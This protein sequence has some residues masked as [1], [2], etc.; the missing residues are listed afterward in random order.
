MSKDYVDLQQQLFD[1]QATHMQELDAYTDQV[2]TAKEALTLHQ[3]DAQRTLDALKADHK[4]LLQQTNEKHKHELAKQLADHESQ[5]QHLSGKEQGELL[6][7][8]TEDKQKLVEEHSKE[9]Q[10]LK[11]LH[12]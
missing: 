8:H 2:D 1:L 7:K 6:K 4:L 11:D 9:L 3:Q 12:V 5:L 10:H